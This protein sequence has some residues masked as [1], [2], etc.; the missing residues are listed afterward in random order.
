M[1]KPNKPHMRAKRH[2]Q[3]T[4]APAEKS[5]RHMERIAHQSPVAASEKPFSSPSAELTRSH[6]AEEKTNAGETPSEA[7]YECVESTAC[8][9]MDVANEDWGIFP[10]SHKK[11]NKKIVSRLREVLNQ[12]IRDKRL[13]R[14]KGL[15]YFIGSL[16]S[17]TTRYE[18]NRMGVEPYNVLDSKETV[19]AFVLSY[20]SSSQ[21]EE[22]MGYPCSLPLFSS[23]LIRWLNQSTADLTR[24]RRCKCKRYF[25]ASKSDE[26]IKFCPICSP[27]N[28]MTKSKR[29]R[30]QRV[31][32]NKQK[33]QG[34]D[35]DTRKSEQP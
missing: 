23:A 14:S 26:R 34:R 7:E 20:A 10:R 3:N 33:R 30:Y 22:E 9:I 12:V 32:R 25:L 15:N 21:G 19:R 27:K 16:D 5:G 6:V 2:L 24:I 11:E 1:K 35:S 18:V 29:R 13:L 28:K 17:F 31:Y 4:D 8:Y